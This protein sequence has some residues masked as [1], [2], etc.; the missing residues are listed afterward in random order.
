MPQYAIPPWVGQPADPAAHFAQ[1]YQIGVHT[2]AQQA[3]QAFQQQQLAQQERKML[4][5]QQQ[6]EY[7]DQM[8]T[9]VMNLKAAEMARKY[10]ANQA[11][12]T[13]VASGEDP[14]RVLMELAPD[15]GESP[16]A[17]L[18]NQAV[19]DQQRAM[20]GYREAN[21][22]RMKQADIQRAVPKPLAAERERDNL[23]ALEKQATDLETSLKADPNN[24]DLKSKQ[25]N[26]LSRIQTWHTQH[27][28][29]NE[30]AL[31][32]DSEGRVIGFTMGPGKIQPGAQA[33]FQGEL[34]DLK[35]SV[36][37]INR[38]RGALAEKDVGVPGVIWDEAVNK[39]VSQVAPE[40]GDP[41][42]SANRVQ[43]QKAVDSYLQ[44]QTAKGRLSAAERADIRDALVSRKAGESLPRARAVLDSMARV[45]QF[46][47]ITK[48]KTGHQTLEPWMF[49][50]LTQTEIKQLFKEGILA[51]DE[52]LNWAKRATER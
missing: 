28:G 19:R 45:Q 50:G 40:A 18:H 25:Q 11:F 6:Q 34:A 38:A 23:A 2:G 36:A 26:V 33:K 37:Q 51:P 5:A 10:Q 8:N 46:D 41:S 20:M 27:P 48:A 29:G 17:I 24:E 47:A 22:E 3:A 42:V 14:S 7:E 43:L 9:Q 16:S 30:T 32:M 49:Q 39:W 13:R 1:G 52:A 35:N 15:L 31:T 12:R 44:T 4:M 21:L